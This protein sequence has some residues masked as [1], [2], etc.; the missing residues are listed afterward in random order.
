[1][2]GEPTRWAAAEAGVK[3]TVLD[4]QSVLHIHDADKRRVHV[5]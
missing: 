1:V 2:I 5:C 4:G 3:L